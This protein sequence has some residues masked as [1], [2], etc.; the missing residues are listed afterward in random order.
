M[1][2]ANIIKISSALMVLTMSAP[3]YADKTS[4]TLPRL[5]API[6]GEQCVEST[7]EMRRN[8]MNY[9]LDHR[10]KTMYF[11]IRTP[12]YSLKECLTCH[13][14]ADRN[15]ANAQIADGEHFCISCHVY[16][17]VKIDCFECHSTRPEVNAPLPAGHPAASSNRSSVPVQGKAK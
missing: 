9:L 3:L 1:R 13:V 2:L 6:Q 15:Q 7:P 17:A 11:G 16:A 8:H 12:K 14:P 5:A 4:Q 10:D